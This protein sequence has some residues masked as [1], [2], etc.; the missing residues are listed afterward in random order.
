MKIRA[1]RTL[2]PWGD[3]AERALTDGAEALRRRAVLAVR[4]PSWRLTPRRLLLLC[5]VVAVVM[6][7]FAD[8]VSSKGL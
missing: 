5:I 3:D 1:Q 7:W 4:L 2:P 8:V 6:T